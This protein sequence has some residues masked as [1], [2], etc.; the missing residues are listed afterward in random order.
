M[1]NGIARQLQEAITKM[2]KGDIEGALIPV[3]LA[4]ASTTRYL[5]PKQKDAEGNGTVMRLFVS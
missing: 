3:S 4:V 1:T 5:Y 2:E